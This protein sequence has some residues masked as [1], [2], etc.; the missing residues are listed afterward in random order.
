MSSYRVLSDEVLDEIESLPLK[1]Q[2]DYLFLEPHPRFPGRWHVDG[3]DSSFFFDFEEEI[4][5][6]RVVSP[7][8]LAQFLERADDL[9]YKVIFVEDPA[10]ILD[11]WDHLN[12]PPEFSLNSDMPNTIAGF[13]PY[14]L[15]G[16]NFLRKTPHG[17][18]AIWSTGTGKTALE[19]GLFK[20][21]L[22]HEDYSLGLIVC[23][24]NNKYDTQSKL[25]KLGGI[26]YAYILDG[27]PKKRKEIYSLFAD[28]L[29]GGGRLIGICNYEK[30]REDTDFFI[31]LVEG[32]NVVIGWDEMPT[33]L[34]N[35]GTVLY[36]AVRRTLYEPEHE[37]DATVS[38]DRIRPSKLRQYDFTATPI[39]NSPIGLLNQVRLIDPSVWPTIKGW[40]KKYVASRNR[41]DR[42][43][44][45]FKSLDLMGLEIEHITH[46]VD[47]SD[48]DIAKMFP[49]IREEVIYV[50]WSSQDRRVYDMLQQIAKELNEEAKASGETR[51]MNA[52][53]LIGVLRMLCAAPSM[54]QQ[55]AEN[56]AEFETIL[57]E[58]TEEEADELQT[59]G[60][61]AAL[62]LLDKL[63]KPLTNDHCNKLEELRVLLQEKHPEEKFLVF[64]SFSGYGF[65]P[66]REALEKWG[67]TYEVY[68]G[69]D[70][71]RQ[72]AKDSFRTNPDT[73]VLLL[74][75]SGSDS[76]DLPEA[77]VGVEYDPSWS[78]ARKTQKRNR[79]HRVNST[80][81][82]IIWYELVY[83]D[84]VEERMREIIARKKGYHD[85]V[86]SGTIA[87][88]SLSARMTRE[89][90]L[91]IL[92]GEG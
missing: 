31:E 56:R 81:D 75:D 83:P 44:E 23:K 70:K 35:R 40:E 15:Q 33:K 61:E 53:Q 92:T 60:S 82:W 89:E 37:N 28:V 55:S 10:S 20:Q 8:S 69:N 22:E 90:L 72:E 39:E 27:T 16:F 30:F 3:V 43:P 4:G 87:E 84:S 85:G 38:L 71:E 65:P 74:S 51:P 46:V 5:Q 26:D 13:L 77:R 7:S 49:A 29:D 1:E 25:F 73:R 34:S 50:D 86:F 57:A 9:R 67:V 64:T 47:K 59:S 11:A 42:E 88:A 14:Q 19:T 78:H 91:Y 2:R 62:M 80:H 6:Y 76:I 36:G 63:K 54:V 45:T 12:D 18:L 68:Q 32:R 52:L 79:N 24:R 58:I 41:F 21:H 17:G 48:P 66:L